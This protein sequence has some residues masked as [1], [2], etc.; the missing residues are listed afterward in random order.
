[1]MLLLEGITSHVKKS[2]VQ[3]QHESRDYIANKY[4]KRKGIFEF[5]MGHK[6][7]STNLEG[8]LMG[9][10]YFVSPQY[11]CTKISHKH[12]FGCDVETHYDERDLFLGWLHFNS[13][14]FGH[15]NGDDARNEDYSSRRLFAGLNGS[16]CEIKFVSVE[17]NDK[18]QGMKERKW[19]IPEEKNYFRFVRIRYMPRLK[20]FL[21]NYF[22]NWLN[23]NIKL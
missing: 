2:S 19:E 21:K 5:S 6:T 10:T 15:S 13:I 23:M 9:E 16:I 11:K 14:Y 1:M 22:L 18:E 17:E 20:G 4:A 3:L 8:S 7:T 12:K